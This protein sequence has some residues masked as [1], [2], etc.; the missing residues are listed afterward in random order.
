MISQQNGASTEFFELELHASD[1]NPPTF[2]VFTHAGLL[3]DL[4]KASGSCHC[5]YVDAFPAAEACVFFSFFFP[6]FILLGRILTLMQA[7]YVALYKEK[8]AAG[9]Q[10][11]ILNS[12]LIGSDR[13]RNISALC[14]SI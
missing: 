12:N 2:R 14:R 8:V 13:V 5:R 1:Q 6:R 11:A 3:A 4:E 10:K 9:F 7:L